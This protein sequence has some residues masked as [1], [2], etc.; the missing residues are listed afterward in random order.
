M[1]LYE[2][3]IHIHRIEQILPW[4]CRILNLFLSWFLRFCLECRICSAICCV[5]CPYHLHV[6]KFSSSFLV[7]RLSVDNNYIKIFNELVFSKTVDFIIGCL[8]FLY[9]LFV[10]TYLEISN[11]IRNKRKETFWKKLLFILNRICWQD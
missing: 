11:R 2:P 3:I 6:D 5:C 7:K 4:D 10:L 8:Y 1:F 9:Y